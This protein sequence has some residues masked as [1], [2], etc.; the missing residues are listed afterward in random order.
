MVRLLANWELGGSCVVCMYIHLIITVY[1]ED[2]T[3]PLVIVL[4]NMLCTYVTSERFI[5][6]SY[7]HDLTDAG[8][9]Q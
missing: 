6:Y 5:N 3:V 7:W 2:G 4:V 9:S 1:R 8:W